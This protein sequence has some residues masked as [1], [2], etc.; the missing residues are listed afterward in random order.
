MSWKCRSRNRDQARC[1]SPSKPGS[2]GAGCSNALP[3]PDRVIRMSKLR[4][5]VSGCMRP[6]KG[7]EE[8]CAI[9]SY[10]AT[11][12]RHGVGCSPAPTQAIPG[13]P[14]PEAGAG[15]Q[16]IPPRAVLSASSVSGYGGDRIGGTSD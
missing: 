3:L 5:E 4:I 7:A 6:M 16:V 8:F 15:C 11:A 10:L 14:K 9:G 12:S 1:Q 13:S 2:E